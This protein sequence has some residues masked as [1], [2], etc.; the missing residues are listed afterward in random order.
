[1]TRYG[2]VRV[3]TAD[4]HEGLQLDAMR[5]AG[6]ADEHIVVERQSGARDDRPELARCLERL[7]AGD[8]L[9]VWRLDR[10]GR[11][12][13]HLLATV[14][15]LGRRGVGF[16]SLTEHL[17]TESPTGRLVFHVLAALAEFER[18]IT[19]QRRQAGIAAARARG[20]HLGRPVKLTS[21]QLEVA[22]DLLATGRSRSEV[23]RV[24]GVDRS[25]LYRHLSE[26]R[27]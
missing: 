11:S 27:V 16:Q 18:D 25:T 21:A 17:E 4:Q 15:D 5:A 24:L 14:E 13:R 23:A 20:K 8:T 7:Q 1:M 10:L 12:M 3:S 2:Y 19:A 26:A 22:A 6:V 9:V